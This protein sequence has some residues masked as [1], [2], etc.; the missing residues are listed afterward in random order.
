MKSEVRSQKSEVRSSSLR[1]GAIAQKFLTPF[2][3]YRT[4]VVFGTEIYALPQKLSA[5]KSEALD[6]IILVNLNQS[7]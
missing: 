2:R 5:L 6:P 1:S 3:R 7:K 4:E